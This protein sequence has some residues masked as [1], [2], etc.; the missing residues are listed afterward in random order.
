MDRPEDKHLI[1]AL[2]KSNYRSDVD[3]LRAI[4]VAAVVLFHLGWTT[5]SGG[6]VGVDVFFVI[7]GY[8]ISRIIWT[9][10]NQGQFSL[11]NFYGRRAR[12]LLPALFVTIATI[13]II[14]A[15][16]L[17]PEQFQDLSES[18]IFSL[19]GL[20]NFDFWWQ[21]GYFDSS[22]MMKPLLHIWTLA[23]ELQF[24]AF[25]PFLIAFAVRKPYWIAF[26]LIAAALAASL[27]GCLWM[28]GHDPTAAFFLVPFRI[29]EFAIG[30]LVFLVEQ[31]LSRTWSDPL[32][33]AG[34]AAIL[35]AAFTYSDRTAYPGV[36]AIVPVVGAAAM[37]LGG[38]GRLAGLAQFR[39]AIYLGK[40]SYSVY[41]IHWPLIV[42][43]SYASG[44][45]GAWQS[46]AVLVATLLLGAA[47]YRFI[48]VPYR[49]AHAFG[50][51]PTLVFGCVGVAFIAAASQS[52]ASGGWV[53]RMPAELQNAYNLDLP[54][55]RKY[56]FSNADRFAKF[57]DFI[58]A[59]PHLLV[60]G[61]SQAMDIVNVMVEAGEEKNF[62]IIF[63]QFG[64]DCGLPMLPPKLA[65]SYWTA[66]PYAASDKL[67]I[68]RCTD[69]FAKM[70]DTKALVHS[71]IVVV[72][73][74]WKE[75]SFPFMQAAIDEMRSRTS[76]PMYF[77]GSKK[78]AG[79]S[80]TL[81]K[82]N[83]T[84][85]G[86]SEFGFRSITGEAKRDNSFLKSLSGVRFVDALAGM[87]TNDKC[88]LFTDKLAPVSLDGLHFTKAGVRFLAVRKYLSIFPFFADAT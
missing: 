59:K 35:F 47:S 78:F 39:L 10:S 37:L 80:L 87:C 14:G 34:L 82:K 46:F 42:F 83:G 63:R 16:L 41:L 29:W 57:S 33:V 20:A 52:W 9:E 67:S 60:I 2:N 86:I 31:R 58:T 49:R 65:D 77:V 69:S 18:T 51:R 36:A 84:F 32:Y 21:S 30:A 40:I 25:W 23:V 24:Y 19:F 81:L 27:A 4:A 7:S 26:G 73:F 75:F 15:F 5:L 3:V 68:G 54:T 70:R 61:D 55:E 64:F 66:S 76:A 53:W 12:R 17:I 44:A 38:Q 85:A 71:D 45:L 79:S 11:T 88:D 43:V 56:L 8:L 6:F 13:F 48:E 22:A 62:E 1:A 28:M 72:A 50:L 74:Y